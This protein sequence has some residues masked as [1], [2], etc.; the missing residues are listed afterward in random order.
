MSRCKKKRFLAFLL[1]VAMLLGVMPVD[2]LGGIASVAAAETVAAVEE[3]EAQAVSGNDAVDT[4]AAG[5]TYVLEAKD[6]TV[7]DKGAKKDGDTE[8][9]GTDKYFT[10]IYS[11]SSA[12]NSSSKDFTD[13]YSSGQRINFGGKATTKKNVI[14]FTTS[15]AATVTVWWVAGDA[16]RPMSIRDASGTEKDS[17]EQNSQKNSDYIST[18][19]LDEAG[20]YYLGGF[21]GNNYIFK[22][23]VAEKASIAEGTTVKGNITVDNKGYITTVTLKPQDTTKADITLKE[24]ANDISLYAGV[25]YDIVTSEPDVRAVTSAGA[26]KLVVGTD[27]VT[28]TITL[29]AAKTTAKVTLA[30]GSELDGGHL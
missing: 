30:E 4:Y 29:G 27:D 9:A 20:T 1:T 13:G 18:L 17:A 11:S 7:F 19:T 10:L 15:A 26:T 12:V 22:V 21:A 6:L 25:T 3:P 28:E 8:S 23:E 2:L 24:G 16:N 14:Q 5:K